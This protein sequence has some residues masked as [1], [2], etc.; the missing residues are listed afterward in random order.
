MERLQQSLRHIAFEFYQFG[1]IR[2]LLETPC[3]HLPRDLCHTV[4]VPL[5]DALLL[6]VR[7]TLD[8]FF[9]RATMG[10][11]RASHFRSLDRS[12][13]SLRRSS[14]RSKKPPS[15][16]SKTEPPS[17]NDAMWRVGPPYEG[18][19]VASAA[20]SDAAMSCPITNLQ[21]NKNLRPHHPLAYVFYDD[22]SFPNAFTNLARY[23]TRHE[24]DLLPR[25]SRPGAPPGHPPRPALPNK[26]N[27]PRHHVPMSPRLP[28]CR[29]LR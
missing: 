16:S 18:R 24:R 29:L 21:F 10:D 3:T 27:S 11:I 12:T 7:V 26:P 8:F 22:C 13:G 2:R 15:G 25:S 9:K 5:Q 17:S 1:T 19:G 23:E 28:V 14:S 6:H 4:R 20:F